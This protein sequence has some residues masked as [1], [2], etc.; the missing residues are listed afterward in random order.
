MKKTFPCAEVVPS[1]DFT[2]SAA[3][4][5]DVL[6]QVAAHAA[7]AHGLKEVPAELVEKVKSAIR[8]DE[9]A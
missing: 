9:S 4:E 3:T 7:E 8:T 1:C 2:A 5:E 6:K